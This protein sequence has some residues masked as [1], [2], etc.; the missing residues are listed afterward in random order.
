M[1]MHV[2]VEMKIATL[3]IQADDQTRNKMSDRE[4]HRAGVPAL[5]GNGTPGVFASHH[6]H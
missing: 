5:G 3:Q 6:L 2:G 1:S 4:R